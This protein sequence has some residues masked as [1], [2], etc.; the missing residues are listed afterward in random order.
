MSRI[1]L[2]ILAT[3]PIQYQ[4]PW[5]RAMAAHPD[6]DIKVFY[7][8]E[9]TSKEQ[10]AAGFGVEF[11]WD[12]PLLEGYP[13]QF[14]ENVA[15]EPKLG[16][17][18]G[19]DT[20]ELKSIISQREYDA[21]LVCG[22][23]FK[24]AWQAMRACW[25]TKTPVMVRGDSHLYMPRSPL[26]RM[27]KWSFYR[28][29][30]P[31]F[32]ACLAVGR[33]SKEYYLHYGAR[34]DRIFFVP[35]V[36]DDD[37]FAHEAARLLPH[38]GQFRRGW[39]LEPE[40]TVFLFAGKFIEKKRPMDFIRAVE[41][42]A[43]GGVKVAGLMVGDGPL[44]KECEAYA[45]SG[46]V[47]V[48]FAGFLNQSEIIRSYIAADALVLPSDGGETWGLVVN[49]AMACGRPCIVSDHVGC[50]PDMVVPGKTGAIFPMGD[51]EFLA[52]LL[53][54]HALKPSSL[55]AMSNYAR[56]TAERNSIA[57]ALEGVVKAVVAVANKTA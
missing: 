52:R 6:L 20:P 5:F 53:V 4:A 46:N 39:G 54:T 43:H 57:V 23:H 51:T 30:I 50:G 31:K 21:W 2:A 19:L 18:K 49:E 29:F 16:N 12:R 28:W 56:A 10:A 48:R 13:Y 3:H 25:R 27:A 34:H 24:S 11:E 15:K 14:L 35:H 37:Y 33:W 17:F 36:I 7:C 32:D 41:R 26:K 8:H 9:A 55:S 22:W 1:R 47:P 44:R 40:C 42:S 38:R 45:R